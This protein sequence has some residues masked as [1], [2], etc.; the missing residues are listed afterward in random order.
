M[1]DRNKTFQKGRGAA[2]EDRLCGAAKTHMHGP[3]AA[4]DTLPDGNGWVAWH[5]TGLTPLRC[6]KRS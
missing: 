3:G 4:M 1:S 6:S 2:S 5:F